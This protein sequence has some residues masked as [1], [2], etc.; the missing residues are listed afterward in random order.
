MKNPSQDSP[1]NFGRI[2]PYSWDR[3][4]NVSEEHAGSSVRGEQWEKY[5]RGYSV[6]LEAFITP[7]S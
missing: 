4:I 3:N 1:Y 7:D 6:C 2:I 5:V